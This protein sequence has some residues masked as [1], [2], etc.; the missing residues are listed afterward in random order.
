[1]EARIETQAR[2]LSGTGRLETWSETGLEAEPEIVATKA[3]LD[4]G[5]TETGQVDGGWTGGDQRDGDWTGD[6]DWDRK[7]NWDCQTVTRT[8]RTQEAGTGTLGRR[9]GA[10]G[11]LGDLVYGMSCC[12]DSRLTVRLV[13]LSVFL[14]TDE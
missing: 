14:Q 6:E 10:V 3:G 4:T 7:G 11:G 1:L 5:W 12:G 9:L 2:R 13:S 8:V